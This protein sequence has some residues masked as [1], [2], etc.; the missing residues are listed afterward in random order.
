MRKDRS[1]WKSGAV[2][3]ALQVNTLSPSILESLAIFLVSISRRSFP[4]RL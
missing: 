4:T 2:V 3:G 1:W